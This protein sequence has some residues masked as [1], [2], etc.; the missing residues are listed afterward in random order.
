[1]T[2]I[3]SYIATI[4]LIDEDNDKVFDLNLFVDLAAGDDTAGNYT[5]NITA[6]YDADPDAST[7]TT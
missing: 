4:D 3:E 2:G 5:V 6:S 7:V 1:M